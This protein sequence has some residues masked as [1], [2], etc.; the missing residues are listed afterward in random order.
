[1]LKSK[2]IWNKIEA[3]KYEPVECQIHPEIQRLFLA[4][5]LGSVED[6]KRDVKP[7]LIWHDPNRFT[8]MKKCLERIKQ[9][10]YSQERILVYG[11]YDADGVTSIALLVRAIKAMGGQVDYY[12]PH[13]FFEGYG[14][15]EDAFMGA[16][17]EGYQLIITVDCGM[18]S[19]DEAHLLKEHGVD[20]IVIDHHQWKEELP[21]G[22]GIIHAAYDENYPF[23]DLAGVGTTL[24]VVEGLKE[25]KL[26]G[27]D[28]VLAML[29]TIGDVVPLIDENRSIVI[30]G[31][32]EVK[33]TTLPGLLALFKVADLNLFD[34]DETT[35]GFSICPRLNAP[36]RMDDASL[37]VELLLSDDEQL[38]ETL[39]KEIEGLNSERK[40][41]TKTVIDEALVQG[42]KKCTAGKKALVLYDPNW[43]EGILG[44]A[45]SK[46]VDTFGVAAALLTDSEDGSVKGSARAPAGFDLLGA[47][48]ANADL[49]LTFG[50]HAVAAG[51]SLKEEAIE[52]LEDGLNAVLA[53]S[54]VVNEMAVDLELSLSEIDLDFLT[55]MDVLA[56]FG[57]GNK[58]PVVKLTDV[59][60][61]AVR[62]IGKNYEHLKFVIK[63]G[64]T[65]LDA[66]F[67]G[68]ADVTIYLTPEARFDVLCELDINEWNGK[69]T[70]QARVVDITCDHAQ[71]L[72]LRNQKLANEFA[73]V[74]SEAFV[75]SDYFASKEALKSAYQT[76]GFSNIVLKKMGVLSLPAREQFGLVYK[77]LQQHAPFNL[78]SDVVKFF[79]RGGVPEA[80]LT[81]I[82]QVFAEL[83]ILTCEEGRVILCDV[84]EKV[85]FTDSATYQAQ[86]AKVEVCEFL[87][88]ADRREI[89]AYLLG[90]N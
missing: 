21:H 8:D 86:A 14:P 61:T 40:A 47:L 35:V 23:A 75:V 48:E 78:N 85:T 68:R 63:E 39:A 16:I 52:P 72:D 24:K 3:N 38:A 44:I 88:L 18:T 45:A 58:R 50:G 30:N 19:I 55:Q 9:A 42:S 56:P 49:M 41:V 36:G 57:Q 15:N 64:D 71:L 32:K 6:L 33:N 89:L 65:K 5:G 12:I 67:F 80:M 37:A 29:G 10:A 2:F 69:R 26:D 59:Q 90:E 11:D 77:T 82:N 28:Y 62:R 1:L 43:H 66:V 20:L 76:S 70:L 34:I 17:G 73:E 51:F 74:T 54:E 4:R 13:R 83:G 27:D 25:G 81:F 87:D 7:S 46:V 84:A 22:I 79:E 60:M 31:L 53:S